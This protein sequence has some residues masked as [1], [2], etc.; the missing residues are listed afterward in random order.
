M[1]LIE[2]TFYLLLS[3]YLLFIYDTVLTSDPSLFYFMRKAE[4]LKNEIRKISFPKTS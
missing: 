4:T 3:V 2:N 1:V